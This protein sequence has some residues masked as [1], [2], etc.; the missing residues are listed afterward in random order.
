MFVKV[1]DKTTGRPHV[2]DLDPTHRRVGICLRDDAVTLGRRVATRTG[3]RGEWL[4]EPE[5]RDRV[6]VTDLNVLPVT[7]R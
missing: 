1:I 3:L 5:Y 7:P 2:Y 4:I 6:S